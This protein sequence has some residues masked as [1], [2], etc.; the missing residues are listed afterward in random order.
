VQ[1][2]NSVNPNQPRNQI[3]HFQQRNSSLP[4]G[5]FNGNSNHQLQNKF[6]E[7]M[8]M[9]DNI[10]DNYEQQYVII[11]HDDPSHRPVAQSEMK[12]GAFNTGD[13]FFK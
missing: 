11:R 7:N 1:R 4:G 6:V 2:A 8:D 3:T 9:N 10:S 5:G 13:K 12:R